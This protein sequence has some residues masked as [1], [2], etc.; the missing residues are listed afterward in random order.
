MKRSGAS[1]QLWHGWACAF[2]LLGLITVIIFSVNCFS[3]PTPRTPGKTWMQYSTPEDA[4]WSN[5]KLEE[6]RNMPKRSV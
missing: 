2:W 6:A 4:G 1:F 5:K 3:E